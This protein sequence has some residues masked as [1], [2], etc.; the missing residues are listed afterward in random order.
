VNVAG[1]ANVA[2]VQDPAVAAGHPVSVALAVKL[3]SDVVSASDVCET[4]VSERP[5]SKDASAAMSAPDDALQSNMIWVLPATTPVISVVPGTSCPPPVTV[6][7]QGA[8][9]AAFGRTAT[10]DAPPALTSATPATMARHAL[11]ENA[12]EHHLRRVRA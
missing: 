5:A 6:T 1:T 2:V 4:D 8:V 10:A 7:L 11:M 12:E 9:D 3:P